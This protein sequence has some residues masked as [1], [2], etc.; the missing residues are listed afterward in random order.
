MIRFGCSTKG[1][2]SEQLNELLIRHWSL[3]WLNDA[4]LIKFG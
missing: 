1:T 4:R 3:V 2:F